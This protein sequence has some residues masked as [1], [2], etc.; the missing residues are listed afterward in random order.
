VLGTH[1][2]H[3]SYLGD[4]DQEDHSSKPAQATGLQD[5]ISKKTITKKDWQRVPAIAS[6]RP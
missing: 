6:I 5:P 1:T 3:P 2:C 4:R